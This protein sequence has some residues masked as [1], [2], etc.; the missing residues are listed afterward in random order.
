MKSDLRILSA[1]PTRT[2]ERAYERLGYP[3]RAMLV[4]TA[5]LALPVIWFVLPGG[6]GIAWALTAVVG[7]LVGVLVVW[8]TLWLSRAGEQS[9]QVLAALGASTAGIPPKLRTRMP[10]VL[11]TGDGLP[12][13]FDRNHEERFAHVGDGAIWLRVDQ[14]QELPRLAVAVRQWRDGRAPDG[15]VLS[16]APA[17]HVGADMLTQKL[18]VVRHCV[19]DA[20]RTLGTRLPGYVAVY[21]RLTTSPPGLSVP[22]WYGVS[23]ATRI[24]DA[25]RFELV[26]R[27][28]EAEPQRMPGDAGS[29]TPTTGAARA[30]A[31]ASLVGWT[32]RVVIGTL[33]DP[34]QPATPWALFGAGWIDCG[35]A[36]GSATGSAD[37]WERDVQMQTCVSRAAVGASPLPWPL[38]QALIEAAPRRYWMSPRRTAC[39]HALA[40]LACAAAVASWSAARNNETLLDRIGTDLGR[41]SMIPAAHDNAKRD[42]LQALVADRDQLDRYARIGV[43]LRLSLG[44]YRGAQLLPALDTAIASYVPPAPPPAVVTLDSMSLFDSGRAQLKPGST[45]AMVGALEMIKTNPD[46]RILVAGHTDNVG[47]PQSNL[48]LSTA[49]AQAVRDWLINASGLTASQFAIQGY[50]E[51]RPIA[52]NATDDGRAKNRRVEITLVPDAPS[53]Q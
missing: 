27:A 41:Y 25:E 44:M 42:A 31:L 49:R 23:S 10:L 50:G 52:S 32:Q 30:A 40:F 29:T 45:R 9:A 34:Q 17:L 4:F 13:L 18:R 26:V 33:T 14:P 53:N 8:R 21:Q 3:L 7:L 24:V 22:A 28:A 39:A 36:S 11:V 20:A 12:A 51:T 38:P 19:A 47:N 46:K 6:R 35:P 43:P 5:V 15:V 48:K 1:T 37:P 16:V 2:P